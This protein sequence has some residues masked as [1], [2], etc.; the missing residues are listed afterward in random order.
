[1]HKLVAMLVMIAG[2]REGYRM[3]RAQEQFRILDEL[4]NLPKGWDIKTLTDQQKSV[5]NRAI[6]TWFFDMFEILA[7]VLGALAFR[8]PFCY[9]LLILFPLSGLSYV[10][11]NYMPKFVRH[12]YHV[13]D[14]AFCATLL[15][16]GPVYF[17]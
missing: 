14:H 17:R 1:M 9:W 4:R 13:L 2:V 6:L 11:H 3:F 16:L 12:V 8:A 10:V 15:I 7:V 5:V